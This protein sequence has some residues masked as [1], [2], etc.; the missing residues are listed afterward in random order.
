MCMNCYHCK[1]EMNCKKETYHYPESGLENV[2][3][4]GVNVC[5][6]DKCGGEAINIPA[7]VEMNNRIGKALIRK[8]ALLNGAEIKYLRKN[9][10]FTGKA[11]AEAMHLDNA[12][13]S[14]WEAGKQKV[15]E[16]HDILLRLIY[17]GIKGIPSKDHIEKDFKRSFSD[18]EISRVTISSADMDGFPKQPTQA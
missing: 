6:C 13:I 11:L 8:R 4:E 9:M 18:D 12:T 2:F 15:S 14:R 16:S 10:G 7:I 1:T 17:C 3:L 5:R